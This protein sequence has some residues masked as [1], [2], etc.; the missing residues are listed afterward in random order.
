MS[1]RGAGNTADPDCLTGGR[2]GILVLVPLVTQNLPRV[3]E[4]PAQE[5]FRANPC[6][7]YAIGVGKKLGKHSIF[8]QVFGCC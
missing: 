1:R 5:T 7:G 8:L 6:L 3:F 2:K 4:C